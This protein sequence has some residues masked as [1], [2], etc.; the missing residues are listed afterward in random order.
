MKIGLWRITPTACS[1]PVA[2]ERRRLLIEPARLSA[3]TCSIAL[4]DSERHYLRRVLRLRIG[5]QVDVVNGQ[6]DLWTVTLD[7]GG[8]RLLM[9]GDS[10]RPQRSQPRPTPLLGLAVALIRRDSDVW[11]RM[12]CELGIDRIQPVVADRCVPQAE[13]REDRW[14]TIVHES[15]EQCERLWAP[16]LLPAVDMEAWLD[17]VDGRVAMAVTREESTPE[18]STWLVTDPSVSPTW[19]LV[20]PEGGWSQEEH[21]WVETGRVQPVALGDNILRSSTAAVRGA[22]EMVRWRESHCRA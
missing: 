1:A 15:V 7:A 5:D 13:R 17:G 19:L 9:A 21:H 22:V 16:T 20:G 12:A 4:L 3:E 8:D 11:I 18:L 10:N 14:Q 6:G 2:R